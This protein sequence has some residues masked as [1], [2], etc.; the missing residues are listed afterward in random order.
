M[1]VEKKS[2]SHL[3]ATETTAGSRRHP[4]NPAGEGGGSGDE[5]VLPASS[6][7]RSLNDDDFNDELLVVT[8]FR[9]ERGAWGLSRR[10]FAVLQAVGD[11]CVVM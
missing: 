3:D 7:V 8:N 6:V 2:K 10:G 1:S 9:Q 4:F 5:S 11:V